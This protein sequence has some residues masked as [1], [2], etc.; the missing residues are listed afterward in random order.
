M[1]LLCGRD[2]SR[3]E[4]T[5]RAGSLSQFA[6]VR[7]VTLGDGA[8]RGVRMFDFRTGAG[9]RFTVPVDRGMDIAAVDHAGRAIGWHSPTG[10]RH[11]AFFEPESEDGLGFTRSFSGF[12]ATCG[13]D[14]ILGAKEVPALN[15]GNPRRA[16]VCHR[17]HGR[18]ANLPARLTGYGE[19]WDG[20]RCILW[21]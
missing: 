11:P 21:A 3:T 4:I 6:G 2:L 14:H 10:F 15:Y 13:L 19:H 18:V 5:M 20:D 12:L 9:L 16:T 7:L 1:T 8:E 17:L